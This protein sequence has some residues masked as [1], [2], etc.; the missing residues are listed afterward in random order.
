M[1]VYRKSSTS[2]TLKFCYHEVRQYFWSRDGDRFKM[3]TYMH[4]VPYKS[5]PTLTEAE[6]CKQLTGNILT[7]QEECFKPVCEKEMQGTC[8]QGQQQI[9]AT[10]CNFK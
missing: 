9:N 6:E 3:D 7:N 10:H 4:K 8:M 5:M 1:G 2:I